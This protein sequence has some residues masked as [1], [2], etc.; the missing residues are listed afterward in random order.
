MASEVTIARE[1]NVAS[2]NVQR[3]SV[4]RA[5]S[6]R[7][8]YKARVKQE[9][10]NLIHS[11]DLP[12]SLS[13]RIPYGNLYTGKLTKSSS[14]KKEFLNHAE[15]LG[16]LDAA[17]AAWNNPSSLRRVRVSPLGEGKDMNNPDNVKN[18]EKKKKRGITNFNVYRM[19]HDGRRWTVKTAQY[20]KGYET[21]YYIG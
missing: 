14:A 11:A 9:R 13:E 4:R 15:T 16:A 3:S 18:I 17:K 6:A 21:F 8:T 5:A 20:K 1:G 10:N 19:N 2:L 12:T 7:Q